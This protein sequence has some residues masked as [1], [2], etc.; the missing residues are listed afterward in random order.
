LVLIIGDTEF[1]LALLGAQDDRLAVHPPDHVEGGLGFAAQRQLQEIGLD[2]G[3]D[4]FAQFGLDG[5]E[6]IRRTEAVEALVRPLVVVVF[7]PKLDAVP[8]VIEAAKLGADQVVLPDG[9]PKPFNLAEGHRMMRAGFDVGHAIL[10]E[11]GG[12]A[13][14]AAP[15]DV[16]AAVVGEHLAG[17][18][19]LGDG[20]AIDLDDRLGGGAAEQ[21]GADDVPGMVIEEG[22]EVGVAA[23]QPEGEDV[24]LPH[25]VGR[26]ALEETGPGKVLGFLFGRRRHEVGLLQTLADGGGAGRQ[27]EPAAQHLGDAGDAEGGVLLFELHDFG[28]DGGGEFLD[29]VAPIGPVLQGV[30]AALLIPF[31]PM[32]Q[33]VL[34]HPQFLA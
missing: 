16:L 1:E 9:G 31:H 15:G 5:K 27:Q 7:D 20:G 19:E 22:D 10:L 2:A 34:I 25:L 28:G 30:L 21:V 17:R 14:G 32:E 24:R 13:A 33:T 12:E 26:G 6:T 11:L 23:A 8:G 29:A 3:L 18:F 4:G